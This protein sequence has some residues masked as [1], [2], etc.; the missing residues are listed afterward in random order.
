M[1]SRLFDFIGPL[2]SRFSFSSTFALYVRWFSLFRRCISVFAAFL[3]VA[4]RFLCMVSVVLINWEMYRSFV[5]CSFCFIESVYLLK[6][7]ISGR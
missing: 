6:L 4:D 2:D 7:F 1:Y 5:V 3:S